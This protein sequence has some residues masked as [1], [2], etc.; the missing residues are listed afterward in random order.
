MIKRL[1][2]I[3]KSRR[4][5]IKNTGYSINDTKAVSGKTEMKGFSSTDSNKNMEHFLSQYLL[6]EIRKWQIEDIPKVL[7][8]GCQSNDFTVDIQSLTLKGNI[9]FSEN[10]YYAGCYAWHYSREENPPIGSRYC[11]KVEFNSPIKAI[12]RPDEFKEFHQFLAK[13]FPSVEPG[14]KLSK[15]FQKAL[16][17]HLAEIYDDDKHVVAYW[18]KGHN[19]EVLIPNCERFI[20]SIYFKQLPDS[21]DAFNILHNMQN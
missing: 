16:R 20:K 21:K 5:D 13:C 19:G 3:F 12:V 7:Y 8:H 2:D 17:Q 1:M 6:D 9:W 18:Y 15:Y 14:Y 4:S 10:E 11:A